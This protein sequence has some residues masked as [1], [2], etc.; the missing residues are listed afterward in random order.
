MQPR[1][2]KDTSG[3]Y[4]SPKLS[5]KAG[6]LSGPLSSDEELRSLDAL[7]PRA[8]A[9]A[10]A[11]SSSSSAAASTAAAAIPS[12]A[13]GADVTGIPTSLLS[14]SSI[15][16]PGAVP[17]DSNAPRAAPVS[18]ARGR[19]PTHLRGTLKHVNSSP[20]MVGNR[21]LQ[22]AAEGSPRT[23]TNGGKRTS[24]YQRW[25]SK[26]SDDGDSAKVTPVSSTSI[27]TAKTLLA[28]HSKRDALARRSSG[29]GLGL[30]GWPDDQQQGSG[31]NIARAGSGR[32][33][34]QHQQQSNTSSRA[35][36]ADSGDSQ[37]GG[38]GGGDNY[39]Q[40][41]STTAQYSLPSVFANETRMAAPFAESGESNWGSSS[42]A[43][44]GGSGGNEGRSGLASWGGTGGAGGG[45]SGAGGEGASRSGGNSALSSSDDLLKRRGSASDQR[46]QSKRLSVALRRGQM[47]EMNQYAEEEKGWFISPASSKRLSW[48]VC[49]GILLIYIAFTAPFRIAFGVEAAGF[50][51]FFERLIDIFFI[52]DIV[53]NCLTAYHDP[54]GSLVTD[55]R[56]MA[57]QYLKSWFFIDVVSSIPVDLILEWSQIGSD[58]GASNLGAAKILKTSKIVKTIRLAKMARMAK[59]APLMERFE[60]TFDINRQ[61]VKILK[62]FILLIVISHFNACG[63]YFIGTLEEDP[64]SSWLYKANLLSLTGTQLT[65]NEV[66]EHYL[67]SFYWAIM[68]TTTVGYGA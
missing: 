3:D 53:L 68:T 14:S 38:E 6:P 60:D 18:A 40:G 1:A 58:G 64:N 9:D 10:N 67:Y 57:L 29:A 36:R 12:F 49:T 65:S 26:K 46:I 15:L 48:D 47:E 25:T 8:A 30:P 28:E 16:L 7:P 59:L 55:R 44:G 5:P 43:G 35:Q 32:S 17:G 45:E 54:D 31:R 11:A 33:V 50:W 22:A 2:S 27:K 63:W 4:A 34:T 21:R 56:A 51:Y 13:D 66:T 52:V 41:L 62:L 37:Q 61:T 19:R 20:S 39:Q 23:P 24:M 42:M